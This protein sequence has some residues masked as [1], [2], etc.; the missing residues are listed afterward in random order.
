MEKAAPRED[1]R[2]GCQLWRKGFPQRVGFA[3]L[4]TLLHLSFH[5]AEQDPGLPC[6]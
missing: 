6:T 1:S 2:I 4:S 5:E 3:A